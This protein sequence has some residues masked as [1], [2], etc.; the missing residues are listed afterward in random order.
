MSLRA[1]AREILHDESDAFASLERL[2][3]H[4]QRFRARFFGW[5]DA[6]ESDAELL[7]VKDDI[8]QRVVNLVS[9]ARRQSADR[10]EPVRVDQPRLHALAFRHVA[11][12]REQAPLALV[13]NRDRRDLDR[14]H[15]PVGVANAVLVGAQSVAVHH[16]RHPLFHHVE[17]FLDNQ[18]AERLA[19][20]V[21][22][23][24]CSE[25]ALRGGVRVAN[26]VALNDRDGVGSGLGEL[27]EPP[28]RCAKPLFHGDAVAHVAEERDNRRLAS[29]HRRRDVDLD[30][31]DL[32]F[33]AE[34][35]DAKRARG[36]A[37]ASSG[38]VDREELVA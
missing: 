3:E 5:D 10:R 28:L 8:G 18:V 19:D 12:E 21:T 38:F 13:L 9:D 37:T 11:A 2:G 27:P 23:R 14:R 17:V 6:R 4:A 35:V 31:D 24:G 32:V 7:Q 30:G 16:L 20:D 25:E 22:L 33:L 26:R 36:V 34:D 15:R 29:K 1:R